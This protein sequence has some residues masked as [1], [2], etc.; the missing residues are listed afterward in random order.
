MSNWP[1]QPASTMALEELDVPAI[2]PAPVAVC[3]LV[4]LFC[5]EQSSVHNVCMCS[6]AW[7]VCRSWK[8]CVN[9]HV[10]V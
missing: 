1:R 8:M 2:M 4:S 3:R 7:T 10:L 9:E 5:T 6:W